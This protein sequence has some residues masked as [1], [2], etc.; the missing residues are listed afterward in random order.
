MRKI[1]FRGKRVDTGQWAY[2]YY[3]YD[4]YGSV[5]LINVIEL[6]PELN[7][8]NVEVD[9][10][11]VGQFV[12][13]FDMQGKEIFEGD[14]LEFP[15]K[16]LSREKNSKERGFIDFFERDADY[17]IYY[18]LDKTSFTGIVNLFSGANIVGEI[19]GNIYD[20]PELLE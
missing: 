7:Q 14:I 10:K 3:E 4:S 11:T 9:S 8:Y 2:G 13:L 5:H 16:K 12:G 1:K 17:W 6:V 19:I 18:N 20:N 15:N